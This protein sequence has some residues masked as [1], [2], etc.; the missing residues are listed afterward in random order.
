VK[1]VAELCAQYRGKRVA[2]VFGGAH[3]Y[4]L[5]DQ[6]AKVPGIT[7]APTSRFLPLTE[8]E[9]RQQFQRQ[10]HLKALRRLN[11]GAGAL[12]P[13]DLIDL[14]KHLSQIADSPELRSDYRFFRA[15]FM[16]HRWD[17]EAALAEFE[18]LRKT[19]ATARLVFDNQSLVAES[20]AVFAASTQSQLGRQKEARANLEQIIRQK[21]VS[22][23]T[24]TWAKQ[25]LQSVPGK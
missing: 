11:F 3:A 24:K 13:T 5:T 10:D 19:D 15:K 14:E 8:D 12:T 22:E 20:A 9:C 16:L 23:Q 2:V 21:D 18:A 4:Y 17:L 6:L 7:V 1:N 25:V